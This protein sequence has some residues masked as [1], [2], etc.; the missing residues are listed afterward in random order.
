[1]GSESEQGTAVD[2]EPGGDPVARES[3]SRVERATVTFV[4]A[5][6]V[7]LGGFVA[8]VAWQSLAV[9]VVSPVLGPPEQLSRSQLTAIGTV[10]T[11]LGTGSAAIAY[12]RWSDRGLGFLDVEVPSLREAGYV[13]AGVVGLFAVLLGM[14]RLYAAV[15]IENAQHS[16]TEVAQADPA[17]LLVLIPAS[18]LLVGPGEE[19]LF[20]NVVQKTLYDEFPRVVS[21][22]GASAVFAAVHFS[23][24]WGPTPLST[25]ASLSLVF[26]L[27]LVLGAAYARTDNVVVPALIHGTFN[28][29]QFVAIYLA[30]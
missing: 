9:T 30:A 20:R 4:A 1:M 14:E 25:L 19:L 16:V 17:V 21:V 29:V 7:G 23:A 15:G 24:Y 18:W 12:L 13:A 3:G 22:V 6:A 27:S 26:V 5:T 10:A 28:G 8:I 11:G 2:H